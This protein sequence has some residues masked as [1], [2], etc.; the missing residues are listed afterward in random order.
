VPYIYDA[1]DFYP[2]VENAATLS[3]FWAHWIKPFERRIEGWCI[4]HAAAVVTVSDGVAQ[5]YK[6]FFGCKA[7]VVRNVQDSRLDREPTQHLRQALQLS[8]EHFLLVCVG[9]AKSGMAVSELFTALLAL[10]PHV[11]VAFVGAR[12][13]PHIE[14]ACSKGL[15]ERVH[16]VPP[17]MPYDVIPFI[18]SADA[19][20][21]IYYPETVNYEYCLPNGFFQPISAQLP[22]LY[23]ELPEIKK[24]AEQYKIG[25]PIDPQSSSSII[26]GVTELM[27]DAEMRMS[28]RQNLHLAKQ[29]LSWE[30]EEDILRELFATILSVH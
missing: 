15:A 30:R 11:H 8:A 24:I 17:V 13:E 28:F 9:N 29:E 1:H 10:P 18:R 16:A 25:I 20:L 6:D 21:V 7:V 4:R 3:H 26:K 19:A 22:L 23:P 27:N 12:Y 5:L 14:L 2:Q